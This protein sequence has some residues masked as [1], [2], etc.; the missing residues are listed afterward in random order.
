MKHVF[1]ALSLLLISLSASAIATDTTSGKTA[2]AKVSGNV[3]DLTA[4]LCDGIF[5][6]TA[7]AN[8]IY[9]W[10]THNIAYDIKAAKDPDRPPP[11]LQDIL[12]DKKAVC[13]G[14]ALLFTEM[15]K[16]AG[17][18]AV[19]IDGYVKDWKFDNGDKFYMPRHAWCAVMIDRRWEL[20]DP[21]F[22]A[23]GT[24][25]APGWIRTQLNRFT[26]EKI[27]F[28]KKEVFEFDYDPQYFLKDPL[29]FRFSHLPADPMWQLAKVHMPLDVFEKGDTAI[30]VFN[31]ENGGR[32]NRAAELEYISRLNENQKLLE[33]ADRAYKFNNRYDLIFAIKEQLRAAEAITKYA[34]RR[35]I[36]PRRTYEDAYRGVVL[37]GGY[38]KKQRSYLPEQ[39]N[40][41]K[42]KNIAKNKEA[43]D[44]IRR[45]RTH[46]KTLIAQCNMHKLSA[47]RK[48]AALANKQDKAGDVMEKILPERIDSIKTS[49]VQKDKTSPA[50][51]AISDS[52]S[53]RQ[54]RLK[55][56]NFSIIERMQ[57]ITLLQ[58]ENRRLSDAL[59]ENMP[60]AD[61]ILAVETE[62]RLNFRDNY[63]DDIKLYMQVFEKVRFTDGDTLQKTYLRN[64]DT[65]VLHYEELLK[66]YLQQA[67]LYKN[68]L[69]D[70]EQYRRWNNSE[71]GILTTYAH[72]CKAYTECISQYQQTMSVY[73][74]YIAD[75]S[76]G[77]ETMAKMY[78]EELNLI[79]RMEEGE[80]A[81]KDAEETA[82]NESKSFDEQENDR[83]QLT[84]TALQQ[85]LTDILS[86]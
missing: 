58:E 23:G 55:K 44:R 61:T 38:L 81:R 43:N 70:L 54:Q 64:F 37:A 67:G 86:K 11:V 14:Y 31:A 3:N 20:V 22:G 10:I 65:L 27:L 84:V 8:L 9:N 82:L 26:K 47:D 72:T 63:D 51:M 75:N 79:D 7:K 49:S 69:R 78:E 5:S 73:E 18:E 76:N 77:F 52:I 29:E 19:R 1:F 59:A 36:P 30:S 46:N 39:Y 41:L 60:I 17:I 25:R 34:S 13:D 21:T 35:N 6:D 40:E 74:N 83:Q 45:I 28:S 80:T 48:K 42:K 24:R 12:K 53:A 16:A 33:C 32:I 66:L 85:Q 68:S 50:L 57:A 56:L 71:E 62:A 2:P 15:C 4:Y